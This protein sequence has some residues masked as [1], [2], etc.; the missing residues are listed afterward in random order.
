MENR[1]PKDTITVRIDN[2]PFTCLVMEDGRIFV[3]AKINRLFHAGYDKGT[4]AH[5][6]LMRGGTIDGK[7]VYALKIVADKLRPRI[8]K[9]LV[10]DGLTHRVH[11]AIEARDNPKARD[12]SEFDRAMLQAAKYSPKERGI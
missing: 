12:L 8:L 9:Q 1:K 5:M 4:A 11:K 10:E 6:A 3:E 7:S 2:E